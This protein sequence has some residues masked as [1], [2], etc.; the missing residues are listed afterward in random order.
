M[1]PFDAFVLESLLSEPLP[2]ASPC[3]SMQPLAAQA[4]LAAFL[5]EMDT[6]DRDLTPFSAGNDS[7]SSTRRVDL[8]DSV[9]SGR[10][11]APVARIPP[12][13]IRLETDCDKA[14]TTAFSLYA[15]DRARAF[16]MEPPRPE[17]RKRRIRA[18]EEIDTLRDTAESLERSL[19]LLKASGASSSHYHQP[20]KSTTF[21][22]TTAAND[23]ANKAVGVVA[24]EANRQLRK[25]VEAQLKVTNKISDE[26]L[27]HQTRA[28]E[29]L[30]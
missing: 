14:I 21:S 29:V 13:V 25:S 20:I 26:L 2:A 18:K 6:F 28:K 12:P 16:A 19:K 7:G 11:S 1:D 27:K 24:L 3:E 15:Q 9:S 8:S 4:A 23:S 5:A 22:I 17:R 30:C 10:S